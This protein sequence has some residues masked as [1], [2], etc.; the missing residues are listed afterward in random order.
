MDPDSKGNKLLLPVSLSTLQY[1]Q[2][3]EEFLKKVYSCRRYVI[4]SPHLD[5]AILSMGDLIFHLDELE[6]PIDVIN[7]FSKGSFVSTPLTRRL[8]NQAGYLT[9]EDYFLKRKEEDRRA[10]K[11]FSNAFPTYLDFPDAPW[12]QDRRK[13]IL[14]QETAITCAH[15][16]DYVIDELEY[17]LRKIAPII[18]DAL[19][20]SPIAQGGH[21][22]HQIVRN[23]VTKVFKNVIYFSDFPYALKNNTD[24]D[25]IKKHNLKS[26]TCSRIRTK[27]K[28]GF[29]HIYG[30]QNLS[31][32]RYEEFHLQPE[33]YYFS[34][35]RQ[36]FQ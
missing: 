14:Y 10:L 3:E 36:L 1:S 15:S 17:K 28:R 13:N 2:S 26:V 18:S 34:P 11:I 35:A 4:F 19:I 8:L 32:S 31:F 7:V 29:V 9:S 25:F 22:D 16:K 5:D 30:S 20:F 6:K 23:I 12:R 33:Q 21:A 24:E 27:I